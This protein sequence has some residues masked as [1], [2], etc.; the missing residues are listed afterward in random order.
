MTFQKFQCRLPSKE[1]RWELTHYNFCTPLSHTKRCAKAF[2]H[3]KPGGKVAFFM[4]R[5]HARYKSEEIAPYVCNIEVTWN[6]PHTIPPTTPN[7]SPLTPL[8]I[9]YFGL[10]ELFGLNS[11]ENFCI[12]F[13]RIIRLK[14][15][16]RFLIKGILEVNYS[17]SVKRNRN[18]VLDIFGSFYKKR[19]WS[20]NYSYSYSFSYNPYSFEPYHSTTRHSNHGNLAMTVKPFPSEASKIAPR[21]KIAMSSKGAPYK[22][23]FHWCVIRPLINY[24]I[25][26]GSE[27][28]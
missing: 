18:T 7:Y 11:V 17:D 6:P 19:I 16:I 20:I 5:R 10:N 2:I 12:R 21:S 13:K 23:V 4:S 27:K 24:V 9:H 22:I 8:T 15:W 3:R 26:L 14:S 28:R 25:W 1:K